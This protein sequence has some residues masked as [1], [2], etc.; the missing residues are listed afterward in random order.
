MTHLGSSTGTSQRKGVAKVTEGIIKILQGYHGS[1][2]FLLEMSA[3]S[4]GVIGSTIAELAEIIKKSRQRLKKEEKAVPS[5][6]VC[7]DTC[8]A[9][10]SG[11]NLTSQRDIQTFI[12]E[13]DH[14]IGLSRLALIHANDSKGA[15][16]DPA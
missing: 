12:R 13:F 2:Q 7:V 11:Y 4:G 9:F 3:G 16:E 8:H 15:L 5:I 14:T 1:C 6:G 10:A